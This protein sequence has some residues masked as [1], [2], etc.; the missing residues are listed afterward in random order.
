VKTALGISFFDSVKEIPRCLGPLHKRFD[1][2]IAIDGRYSNFE[3][4]HDYSIDGS[5]EMIAKL[6]NAVMDYC[7]AFQPYKRQRYLDIAGELKVDYLVVIDTD[8]YVHPIYSDWPLFWK[9]LEK[10]ATKYPDYQLFKIKIWISKEWDKAHNIART[11]VWKPYVRIHKNPGEQRYCM[12]YHYFWCHK[13][14]TDLDILCN[15]GKVYGAFK[16]AI[17]GVRFSLNSVLRSPERL[18]KNDEWAFRNIHDERRRLYYKN[19]DVY[20]QEHDPL[21]ENE[22]F[23]YDKKTGRILSKKI[24]YNK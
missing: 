23:E 9:N 7:S 18:R 14:T 15:G 20:K 17:D 19:A 24:I 2:V 6:P 10:T 1:Y 16:N 21:N 5:Y 8:E 22:L 11:N 13:D 3:A 12:D 4:D